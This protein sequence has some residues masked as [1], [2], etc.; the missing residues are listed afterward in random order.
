[1]GEKHARSFAKSITWRVTSFLN[2]SLIGV[3]VS[4]D[5][6]QG[7][8]IGVAEILT[9]TVLYYFHERLWLGVKYGRKVMLTAEGCVAVELHTRTF[10]KM[11][12]WRLIGTLD[13]LVISYFITGSL[14]ASIS[15]SVLEFITELILYYIHER[16]WLKVKWGIRRPVQPGK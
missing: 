1:M 10:T 4:G 16:S 11:M 8:A 2:T 6:F 3:V 5:P 13:T 12:S 15:I 14:A 9:K 7:L